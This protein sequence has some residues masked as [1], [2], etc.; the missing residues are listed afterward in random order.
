[1]DTLEKERKKMKNEKKKEISL[2]QTYLFLGV[3]HL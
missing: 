2:D 3:N 1:M